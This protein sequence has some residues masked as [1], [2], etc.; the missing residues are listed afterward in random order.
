MNVFLGQ[1]NC[2]DKAEDAHTVILPVPAE[3]STS[4][5][6][7]TANGPAAIIAASPYLEFYDEELDVE[8][9]KKGIYTAAA[10]ACDLSPA[11][12]MR[13]IEQT[14]ASYLFEKKFLIV[15][16]GEHSISF[17]VHQA[18]HGHFPALSVLQFDAH[19]DLRDE[20]EGSPY[21]HACVMRRIWEKNREI[22]AV[23]IRSQCVEERDFARQQDIDITYAHQLYGRP[24]PDEIIARL[25]EKVYITFDVDFLDPSLM[26]GTGTPE[27]GG[28]FWPETMAF[29]HRVF[30]SKQVVAVDVVEHSPISGLAHPDFL[31][32]KLIYKLIGY[33][34]ESEQ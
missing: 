2:A 23:G 21:S 6:K 34:V 22:V 29:L 19:S 7:G 30:Q 8:V 13:S 17:A 24:F 4:Y 9:W 25:S 27:P 20:Y 28:F 15:L 18:V 12:L 11:E 31:L 3:F 16:G 33:K 26:P 14:V 10:I 32:A 1:A 5:G